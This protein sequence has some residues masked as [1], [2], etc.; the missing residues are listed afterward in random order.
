MC[1]VQVY[2]PTN[3]K[4]KINWRGKIGIEKI[5]FFLMSKNISKFENNNGTD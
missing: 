1:L 5:S 2:L 4:I 3:Y